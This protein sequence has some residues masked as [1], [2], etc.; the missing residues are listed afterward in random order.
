MP[1]VS[2]N[3]SDIILP[4]QVGGGAVRGRFARLG[5]SVDAI[6]SGHG[7][8]Q[9]VG[10][11]LAETLA[12]ASVLAGSLKYDGVFTLQAQGD[13]P[14]ALVVADVTSAGDLRGYARFDADKVAAVPDRSVASLLGKGYLAFTV[15]QGPKTDRYQGIVELT[16]DTLSHCAE[17]YFRQSEQLDTAVR[18]ASAPPADGSGWHA[19][20]L[21]IQ[22]MPGSVPG[23]PILTAHQ[24]EDA[25]HTAGVLMASVTAAE[26][27][28]DGLPADQ[29]AYRLFHAEGLVVHE[30]KPLRAQCRCSHKRVE[31]TLRSFPRAEVEALKDAD[32]KVV[33]TCEFCRA[34]YAFGDAELEKVYMP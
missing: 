22:R 30:P 25:W 18:L 8:P 15:D 24:S 27:L 19:G 28:D 14:V 7:Y 17:E 9:P 13:G 10:S 31:S 29:V 1:V 33:V 34:A 4:F 26:M 3:G 5:A 2:V 32:G 16:G 21:M 6:L 12:L 23:A 11:L 20:A